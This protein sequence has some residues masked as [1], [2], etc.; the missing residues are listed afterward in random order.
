[1]EALRKA[2]E[3]K[4][5]D[6][7]ESGVDPSSGQVA[8]VLPTEDEELGLASEQPDKL[9]TQPG[10]LQADFDNAL[11]QGDGSEPNLD[12]DL[13]SIH[14]EPEEVVDQTDTSPSPF[15]TEQTTDG[16][17]Q[18]AVPGAQNDLQAGLTAAPSVAMTNGEIDQGE[19]DAWKSR[20][21]KLSNPRKYR[22]VALVI[23]LLLV[24]GG[25]LFWFLGFNPTPPV[26]ITVT[27][28]GSGFLGGSDP[29]ETA[30]QEVS[31]LESADAI[32]DL[33]SSEP[34]SSHIVANQPSAIAPESFVIGEN[35][36]L[37]PQAENSDPQSGLAISRALQS[38][39]FQVTPSTQS[40]ELEYLQN[41]A[42]SAEQ[43]GYSHHA[44]EQYEWLLTAQPNNSEALMG[45]ARL[46]LKDG[47]LEA[48]RAS[49]LRLLELDPSDPL[50]QAGLLSLDQSGDALNYE[51]QLKALSSQNPEIAPLSF[52]LGNLFAS[53]RRW[54]EAEGAY[55]KALASA[56][57][58]DE[59]L[60][61]PDY[62]FNLAVALEQL[63]KPREAYL[64]YL[65]ALEFSE[66]IA[67]SFDTDL[68][69]SRIEFLGAE[70]Q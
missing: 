47:N 4:R 8:D 70:L 55:A 14:R 20:A 65:V 43:S 12:L 42:V 11:S 51:S 19:S 34:A 46:D 2:E 64:N 32:T 48:V 28:P 45:L 26:Q 23:L 9:V 63:S 44:R 15:A 62:A 35:Q 27:A 53:Q 18:E 59:N 10:G 69:V 3:A 38:D 24:T 17:V 29:L 67:P 25:V 36:N 57:I 39:V 5:K 22:S 21:R 56:R 41:Q 50:A 40:F 52:A 54:N 37:P 16:F 66:Q 61:S 1:M 31:S 13:H 68:L 60:V 6:S 33:P 30:E 58:L 49:Y 7:E